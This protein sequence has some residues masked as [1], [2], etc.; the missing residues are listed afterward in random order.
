MEPWGRGYHTSVNRIEEFDRSQTGTLMSQN[1]IA[2]KNDQ[3]LL[4]V[5]EYY[6]I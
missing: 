5:V 4:N 1:L 2:G 6:N 3:Q